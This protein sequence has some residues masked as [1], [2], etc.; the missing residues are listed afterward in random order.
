MTEAEWLACT[1]PM[2]MLIF[3]RGKASDR[4]FRLFACACCRVFW[5]L[6]EDE[7]SRTAVEISERYADGLITRQEL[8][9]ARSLLKADY[10]NK[11]RAAIAKAVSE[12]SAFRWAFGWD[13]A[14]DTLR[15][16]SSDAA[17]LAIHGFGSACYNELLGDGRQ[18]LWPVLLLHDN[19]GP[20]LFRHITLNPAW[21]AWNGAMVP[22]LAQGI[23]DD[24]AFDRLPIL[25]DALEEAGCLNDDILTH[26][27][28][29]GPHA[30]GCWVVDLI[31]G[32]Q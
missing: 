32:K 27:R 23:Y 9:S 1:D 24:R 2:P 22:K 10:R 29:P 11:H 20:L 16:K 28:G 4:K 13:M 17:S 25:A 15:A 21:L 18:G 30:R 5:H 7:R 6:V 3:L 31:L 12:Q 26:C 19:F 14:R 8:A